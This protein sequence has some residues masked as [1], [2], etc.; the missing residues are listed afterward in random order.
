MSEPTGIAD[1]P[2]E[3]SGL[4]RR[5]DQPLL[6]WIALIA[7]LAV[8][9]WWRPNAA[10]SKPQIEWKLLPSHTADFQVNINTATWPEL[11]QLPEIG[12]T[13]ARRIVENR[14]KEGPFQAPEDVTRVHGIGEKT[15]EPMRRYLSPVSW[16]LSS[17]AAHRRGDR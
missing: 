10:P 8:F 15:L 2:R 14:R 6:A 3:R 17:P 16:P 4:L 12:D 5:R 9:I 1:E 11:T 13:L 7:G